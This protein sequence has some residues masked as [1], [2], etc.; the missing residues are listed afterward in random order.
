MCMLF[1]KYKVQS[2]VQRNVSYVTRYAGTS[3]VNSVNVGFYTLILLTRVMFV[4]NKIFF[5][6]FWN[7]QRQSWMSS[8]LFT[9]CSIRYIFN[10]FLLKDT[11]DGKWKCY[12]WHI[13]YWQRSI[14]FSCLLWLY[15][16]FRQNHH[17]LTSKS[18]VGGQWCFCFI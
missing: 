5:F 6:V 4:D 12:K 1:A 9:Y 17:L 15:L 7:S 18:L 13:R 10:R 14:W 3:S 11:H 2:N 8:Y 16:R